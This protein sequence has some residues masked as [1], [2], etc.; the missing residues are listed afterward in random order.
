MSAV[1]HKK[2]R[3]QEFGDVVG[4]GHV[5]KSLAS[6]TARASSQCFLFTGPS[7][8]GKT[9]LARIT[10]LEFGVLEQDILEIAAAVYT[11]VDAMRQVLETVQYKPFGKGQKKALIID[12]MHRL[13]GQAVDSILK[14]TE[15]PPE[16]VIWLFCTTEPGKV[17]AALK[18]RS[19]YF[20]LKPVDDKQLLGLVDF[21]CE[22]EKFKASESVRD[23]IVKEAQGS[24]RQALVYLEM[25]ADVTD[26]KVAAD[27]LRT[28]LDS[29]ATI[30]LA[31]FILAAN[32][33]WAK[34]MTIFGKLADENPEGIRIVLVNY[35]GKVL[36][37]AKSEKD[38]CHALRLLDC[39]SQPY[40]PSERMAPLLQSI[41]RAM[42]GAG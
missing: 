41:G 12:E 33:S 22:E 10:A 13:S 11:G 18:T 23:M 5:V 20:T 4:Q 34:A 17:P 29:D 27:L 26:R 25:C 31:R 30:E 39:F 19:S 2:Y 14:A 24:P 9:T 37:G 3:P 28:A 36:Q 15:E 1:L 38:A 8:T 35:L 40:N 7:G 21:V 42:Y 32:G 6:I 16:H